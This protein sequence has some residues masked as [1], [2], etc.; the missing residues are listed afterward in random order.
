MLV[1]CVTCTVGMRL[2]GLWPHFCLSLGGETS[3]TVMLGLCEMPEPVDERGEHW[4][5]RQKYCLAAGCGSV[6]PLLLHLSCLSSWPKSWEI[7]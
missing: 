6:Q 7:P 2:S 1:S 3:L 4:P 5:D